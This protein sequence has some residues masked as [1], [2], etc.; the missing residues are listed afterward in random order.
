MAKMGRPPKIAAEIKKMVLEKGWAWAYFRLTDKETPADV[1]DKFSLGLCPKDVPQKI[2]GDADNPIV[3]IV[4]F[5][6][7]NRRTD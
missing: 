4:S 3:N 2:Q 7:G 5:A 6:D 1:K